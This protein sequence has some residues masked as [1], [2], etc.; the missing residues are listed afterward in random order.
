[1]LFPLCIFLL[2]FGE[3][4]LTLKNRGA[5]ER[6]LVAPYRRGAGVPHLRP[7]P[8]P[9][10]SRCRQGSLGLRSASVGGRVPMGCAK[11]KEPGA[12]ARPPREAQGQRSPGSRSSGT[13]EG[14]EGGRAPCRRPAPS[15]GGW[16]RCPQPS[17]SLHVAGA[18]CA[19]PGKPATDEAGSGPGEAPLA[20]KSDLPDFTKETEAGGGFRGCLAGQLSER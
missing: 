10:P 2:I 6:E 20:E 19:R 14:R 17:V 9:A 18:T 5:L 13:T 1:M 7:R 11:S 3:R 15:R 4:I 16:G 12:A 8:R